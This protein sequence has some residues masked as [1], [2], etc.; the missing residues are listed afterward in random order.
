LSRFTV[1]EIIRGEDGVAVGARPLEVPDGDGDLCG[2]LTQ[3]L[4]PEPPT[5]AERRTARAALEHATKRMARGKA[6]FIGH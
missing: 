4:P 3:L 2:P 6:A 5:P 1:R